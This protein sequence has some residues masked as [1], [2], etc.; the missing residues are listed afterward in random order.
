MC[1]CVCVC[2]CVCARAR[3]RVCCGTYEEQPSKHHSSMAFGIHFVAKD[4]LGFLILLPLS[5]EY[6]DNNYGPYHLAY[7]VPGIQLR[8]S[9]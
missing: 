7:E 8:T 4:I 1:V 6:W 9:C 5:P 2:V 3:A